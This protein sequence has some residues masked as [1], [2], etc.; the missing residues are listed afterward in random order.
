MNEQIRASSRFVVIGS[1]LRDLLVYLDTWPSRG[2]QSDAYIY[3]MMG[4]SAA[5]LAGNLAKL[6]ADTTLVCNLGL[7]AIGD[8]LLAELTSLGVQ[9]VAERIGITPT[10]ICLVEGGDRTFVSDARKVSHAVPP[11]SLVTSTL[12][13]PCDWLHLSGYWLLGSVDV[14]ATLPAVRTMKNSGTYLSVDLGNSSTIPRRGAARCVEILRALRPHV[15][16]GNIREWQSL[17]VDP[18]VITDTAIITNDDQPVRLR[19]R[20]ETL[21]VA[22]PQILEEFDPVGAGDSLAAAYMYYFHSG[23]NP[24]LALQKA[25]SFSQHRMKDRAKCHIEQNM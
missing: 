23:I 6:G 18:S 10:V 1:L 4:G 14:S 3:Q 13:A 2:S 5:L 8:T 24:E 16:F 9:T 11:E 21:S 17:Q 15:I 19:T 7:D 20:M 22:V 12:N 25:I